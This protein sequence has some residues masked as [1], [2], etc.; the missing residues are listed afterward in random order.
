MTFI[1]PITVKFPALELSCEFFSPLKRIGTT[2]DNMRQMLRVIRPDGFENYTLIARLLTPVYHKDIDLGL[3]NEYIIANNFTQHET[4]QVELMFFD[5]DKRIGITNSGTL[6][7]RLGTNR[8]H[9]AVEPFP[10]VSTGVPYPPHNNKINGMRNGEWVPIPEGGGG[11][12]EGG[13]DDGKDALVL[14]TPLTGTGTVGQVLT[15][16]LADFNRT[17]LIGDVFAPQLRNT[18]TGETFA[19][20]AVVQAVTYPN[21]TVKITFAQSIRG[22]PGNAGDAATFEIV[23]TITTD[24]AQDA[25]AAETSEST[26]AHRKYT[27][28]VPRGK[29]GNNGNAA[30]IAVGQVITGN[31]GTNASVENVGTPN[32]AVFR[33]TIPRGD[34]GDGSGGGSGT[35]ATINVGTVTTG[36]PG[37]EV[38]FV[39]VGTPN[40]AV[41]DVSIPRGDPGDKG[42][43]A[44][45]TVGT[46]STGSPGTNASVTNSGTEHDAV[47]D[48]VIPRGDPGAAATIEIGTVTTGAAGS[49]ATVTNVGT[50]NAARWNMTIPQGIK[51][52]AGAAATIAVGN[53]TTGAPGSEASVTNTGTASNAILKFVIPAGMDGREVE[54]QRTATYV[55]WRR[56]GDG[57][58]T[59]LI[60][61]ADITGA[62]GTTPVRGV[63]FWT[64]ADIEAMETAM[65]A[66]IDAQLGVIINDA[67]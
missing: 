47:L 30:T 42:D 25:S 23:E 59:N 21:A 17:P 46:V 31:A 26:S 33:F 7:Y 62:S 27:L 29:D 64:P 50:Q 60:A 40:A 54:F 36:E 32:A 12:G 20:L 65:E 39:N 38:S 11:G 41:F 67:N 8:D 16:P 35:A 1:I 56:V 55:Q 5:G 58:W 34:P 61:I 13:G 63:D 45:V 51:G 18:T 49:N 2:G 4:L 22:T 15:V 6:Y 14:S 3:G 9:P 19:A 53:V 66:Y 10:V 28:S 57:N 43:A 52:D 37:S 48:V 44:T 24:Y